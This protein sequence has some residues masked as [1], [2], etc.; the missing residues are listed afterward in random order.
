METQPIFYLI[1]LL[2]VLFH[3]IMKYRDARTKR[4]S[5]D[6]KYQLS[7]SLFSLITACILVLF[8]PS[9]TPFLPDTITQLL[10]NY[11]AWFI[12]SYFVDS[13]WKN[14]E[15]VGRKKLHVK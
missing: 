13:V 6:I 3:L 2:G 11:F 8:K 14:V 15:S 4:E 5:F 12:I 10:N 7:F 9:I 1:A